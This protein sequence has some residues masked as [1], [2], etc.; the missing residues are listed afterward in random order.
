M[1]RKREAALDRD[2]LSVTVNA[3]V[4]GVCKFFTTTPVIMVTT[5]GVLK[6]T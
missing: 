3:T 1:L 5:C 4:I 6:R 2:S